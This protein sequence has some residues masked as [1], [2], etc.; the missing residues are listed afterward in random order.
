MYTRL[1]YRMQLAMSRARRTVLALTRRD[2]IESFLLLSRVGAYLVPKYRFK[3][4]TLAW[5]GDDDFTAFLQRFGESDGFKSERRWVIQQLVRLVAGVPGNTAE[6]GSYLGAGSY[7]IA[8]MNA[9]A[10]VPRTHHV[11]DSFE[12]LSEPN[13]SDGPNWTRGDLA[14]SEEELRR[15]SRAVR[16]K[17]RHPQGLDSGGVSRPRA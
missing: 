16:S 7:L 13:S 5:W 12:G 9:T 6:C 14:A 4:P 8:R 10:P 2:E 1:V 3:R 15:N 11:I 17:R